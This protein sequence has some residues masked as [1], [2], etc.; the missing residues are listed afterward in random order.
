MSFGVRT[1]EINIFLKILLFWRCARPKTEKSDKKST[2]ISKS[3]IIQSIEHSGSSFWYQNVH[4]GCLEVNWSI[5]ESTFKI[6]KLAFLAVL[7]HQ[8]WLFLNRFGSHRT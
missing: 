2:I 6:Y 7:Y 4:Y 3:S 1:K 5:I 8:F